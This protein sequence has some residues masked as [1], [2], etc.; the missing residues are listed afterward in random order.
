VTSIE[1]FVETTGHPARPVDDRVLP[2]VLAGLPDPVL[3]VDSACR[4][5]W[6]NRAAEVFFGR[7]SE[8]SLGMSGLDLVHPDDLDFALIS[9]LTVQGKEAGQPIEVR[10]KSVRG[11]RL[12]ELIGAPMG[13]A[14]NGALVLS[15]RDLTDRRGFEVANDDDARFRSIVHNAATLMMFV[16]PDGTVGA[17]SGAIARLLGQDPGAVVGHPMADLVQP[18]DRSSLDAGLR[19]ASTGSQGAGDAPTIEV[20]LVD[21]STGSAIPFALTIVNLLEDPTVGG[22]IVTGHDLTARKAIETELLSTLSLLTA[23]LD[24]TADG[25]LVVDRAGAIATF[26]RKF[27]ELWRIP[28][29]ILAEKDDAAAITFVLEQLVSPEA[30]LAK[31]TELYGRPE[32]QSHDILHFID[33]RV[34]ERDSQPHFI[35]GEIAGRVWSFRDITER[36]QLEEQLAHQALHDS[37]TNL[38]NQSLFRDRV[39]HAL[40]RVERTGGELAVLFLDL[41]NFKTVNDSL[42]HS[43][44]DLLLLGVTE[45]LQACLRASDTAARLGGDEFAVLLEDSDGERAVMDVAERILSS[46]KRT[47]TIDATELSA[48]ASIGVAFATAGMTCDQLLRNAD[49]AMYTAKRRGKGRCEPYADEMHTMAIERLQ[50]EAELRR[51]I[52]RGE[53]TP[54]YQPIVELATGRTVGVEALARWRHPVR[55]LLGPEVF[56]A[57]AEETGLIE[58]IGNLIL[59]QAC[60]DLRR[61]QVAGIAAPAFS[62]SVNLAPQQL[63]GHCLLGEVELALATHGL[64][65]SCLILEITEGAMMRDTHAAIANLTRLRAL[66][67]RVAVDDFG[68]GYSSLAYLQ[69]F[70]LDILKID[71]SFVD[72]IDGGPEQSALPHAIIRLA[73]TLHL[74]PIAEGVERESQQVRLR[75]LGCELA[76]GYYL[77]MP[78]AADVI[79]ATLTTR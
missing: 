36:E 34:F 11:W 22:F 44:G 66:G 29:E 16:S 27:A 71:K 63:V 17:A 76:Q 74:E 40:A 4:L 69:R 21:R 77:A 55:G 61:W 57:L 59:D 45:R 6:G 32:A 60:A 8:A 67:I 41:D 9:L 53:I 75:E 62:V 72:G 46:F 25:I 35:D 18:S 20:G 7:T 54:H 19:A 10:V 24:S 70:P 26:N 48:S 47:F 42:G 49:L 30:F 1:L 58:D 73:Q 37:L 64:D 65:P 13:H 52:D 51:A 28:E 23:T 39:E 43:A 12:V 56:I 15:I 14:V 50:L 2:E 33:G 78:V 79:A 5:L 3:V 31:I 68:T 38:A